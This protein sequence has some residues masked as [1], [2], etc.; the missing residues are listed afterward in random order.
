MIKAEDLVLSIQNALNSNTYGLNFALFTEDGEFKK[1]YRS[2]NITTHYVNGIASVQSSSLTPITGLTI[3]EMSV[4]ITFIVD[5]ELLDKDAN[6]NYVEVLKVLNCLREYAE[7]KNGG[8]TVVNDGENNYTLAQSIM[9]PQC[10]VEQQQSYLGRCIPIELS[11][12]YTMVENGINSNN[13][14]LYIYGEKIPYTTMTI[15]RVQTG[16]A[17]QKINEKSAKTSIEQ[18]TINIGLEMPLSNT[19]FCQKCINDMLKGNK[20]TAIPVIIRY[21]TLNFLPGDI[22]EEAY[23]CT[24]TTLKAT[25]STIQNVGVALD[26]TEVNSN[27]AVYD[28]KWN[29]E[30]VNVTEL[31]Y[32]GSVA[33]SKNIPCI[34]YWG[35]GT[36]RITDGAAT[37]EHAY[38]ALGKYTIRWFE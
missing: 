3:L 4:N 24:Y 37:Y 17:S 11:L 21:P 30:E 8:I 20:N 33:I 27:V 7:L 34:I 6:G 15:S 38:T 36:F 9:L 25:Q 2:Q 16:T 1:A 22:P 13:V 35:D 18:D 19:L 26:L 10:G 32:Y 23:I 28:E 29:S 14:E 12:D 31:P 5:V